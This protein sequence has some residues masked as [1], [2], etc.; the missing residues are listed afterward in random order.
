[1]VRFVTVTALF[2]CS[3]QITVG[4]Q[5]TQAAKTAAQGT[6]IAK[7]AITATV[8]ITAIDYATRS[9]TLRAPD[10][11]EQTLTAGPAV[12]RFDQLKVGDSIKATYYE[13]WVVEVRKSGSPGAS[14]TALSAKRLEKKPGGSVASVQTATVTVKAIDLVAQSITVET[15]DG[16]SVTRKIADATKLAGVSVGDQVDIVFTQS[17]MVHAEPAV[18]K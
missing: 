3:L 9:I 4:A 8:Q 18:A 13:S 1:M 17:L 6:E 5:D 10:G 15:T 12:A 16:R 14:A 7:S 2:A 11:R